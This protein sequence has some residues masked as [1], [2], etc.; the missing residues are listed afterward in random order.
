MKVLIICDKIS[1]MKSIFYTGKP[2]VKWHF[3]YVVLTILFTVLTSFSSAETQDNK[4]EVFEHFKN[5][6][7]EYSIIPLWSWNSN[8]EPNE[9]KRQ[10]D[11]MMEKGIY[12][13]FMHARVGIDKGRTPYFSQGWWKAVEA[14]VE[15]SNQKGFLAC[16]YDEDGWP[17][18]SAGGRTLARNPKE[19]IKKGL[20]YET[21]KITGPADYNIPY[22]KALKV[23]AVQLRGDN[24]FR[25]SSQ[26]DITDYKGHTWSVP[27]GEWTILTFTA[28]EDPD[29]QIDYLDAAAVAAFI[30][31]THEEYFRRFGKYFGN[32]I[33]GIFFDEISF[34][35]NGYAVLP[36]TD[37]LAETFQNRKG[38]N[39]LD[40]LPSLV[41][42]S[43]RT[44][45]VNYDFM[46]ELSERYYRAWFDQYAE[47]CEKHNIWMTGH[48]EEYP[49][50]YKRQG[51][52][53]KT[54]GRLNRPLTDNEEFRYGFPRYIDAFKLR[55]VSSAAHIYGRSR[56]GAEAMGGGGYIITPE[57]YRYGFARF[58]VCGLN[59]FIPH[60]FH[61][62]LDTVDAIEDWPPSW[63]FANPYWKYFKP[64]ADY[65]RRI[66]YMNSQGHHICHV[67]LLNPLTDQWI[68]GYNETYETRYFTDVQ[69]I[70]LNDLIEYDIINPA[71][72]VSADCAG[73]K[74][75]LNSE[76]YSALVLPSLD[77]VT[78]QT[79]EKI[80]EFA[81]NGGVVIALG[82]IPKINNCPDADC[83]S[84]I[85]KLFGIDSRFAGR[86]YYY[87]DGESFKPYTHKR[88]NKGGCAYFSKNMVNLPL[89]VKQC[90]PDEIRIISGDPSILRFHQRRDNQAIFYLL[91]NES[92]TDARWH[93]SFPDYGNPFLLNNETGEAAKQ[94]YLV[95]GNRIEL[96]LDFKPWQAFYIVFAP[97]NKPQTQYIVSESTLQQTTLASKKNKL[98][99]SGYAGVEPIQKVSI[100]A[101]NG[102]ESIKSWRNTNTLQSVDLDGLWNF[103][104]V[105]RQIDY[106][107]TDQISEE[108]L[109]IPVMKFWAVFDE[110]NNDMKLPEYDD[111]HWAT[112]K[113]I[114]T[115]SRLKGSE[116]YIS[117]WNASQI[118][119]YDR[120]HHLPEPGG[121][122]AVFIKNLNIEGD[123]KNALLTIA[124][125]PSF[126]LL[127]NGRQAGEGHGYS[128]AHSFDIA[129]FLKAGEN[130]I[131]IEVPKNKGL[132]VEGSIQTTKKR[133]FILS[134]DTWTV[135]SERGCE[136]ALEVCKPPMGRLGK[137]TFP[138]RSIRYPLTG[139]YRQSLPAGTQKIAIPKSSGHLTFY[140]DGQEVRPVQGVIDLSGLQK[141]SGSVLAVKCIFSQLSDGLQEPLKVTCRAAPVKLADWAE[142]GLGWFT[143]WGIYSQEI[144]VPAKYLKPG[145][146][147]ILDLGQV[148]WFAELWVNDKLV[149]FFPWGDFS[150]DVTGYLKPGTNRISIIVSNLRANEAYWNIPDNM[151]ENSKARWWHQ[152][153]TDREKERLKSGLFGP[154]RLIPY[155]RVEKHFS[156]L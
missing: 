111:S 80:N 92:K 152:G 15:Y 31:I 102:T 43:E 22:S 154:V 69:E 146:K 150:A 153:A 128:E 119:S 56:I 28:F 101:A 58:G 132:L 118:V 7:K 122:S 60:L 5:P 129:S 52:Y 54:I 135:Q 30:D 46:D 137:A 108:M 114:D 123:V 90:I 40:D 149:K 10:I 8:L 47:W 64:L 63:F 91:M 24:K 74:I 27:A 136:K 138:D 13:A 2:I 112:I 59:F 33:A 85:S 143:G 41:F 93:L 107:W 71:S 120:S 104:P 38:Y 98:T 62:S 96:V 11:L 125:N 117:T 106:V 79:A 103:M 14:A 156:G 95:K 148:N 97:G 61:Y 78:R 82:K 55:Q 115:F 25:A 32:T 81:D 37:D 145:I 26:K 134:N 116:R 83:S 151:L 144:T 100:L 127:I 35:P 147:I 94:D 66:S 19:F 110:D 20:R 140:V 1:F 16:L 72:L 109:D 6:P 155:Q 42:D 142:Y 86:E 39:L 70:L 45:R 89:I 12:G 51:D 124:A 23:F 121:E 48:T 131:Q 36:W 65:G 49:D 87:V 84:S 17:S 105:G 113:L 76:A 67:A 50:S 126:R 77:F 4:N 34:M 9:L 88:H 99:I 141:H 53:I 73:G 18:G 44:A 21:V 139:W 29:K 130:S 68:A 75:K 133:Y 57:E 3:R